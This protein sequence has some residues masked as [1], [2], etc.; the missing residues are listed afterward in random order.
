VYVAPAT[1][2]KLRRLIRTLDELTVRTWRDGPFTVLEEYVVRTGV[3][4]DQLKIDSLEAKRTV[5][6][7]GNFMRF[8]HDWQAEHPKG[9]LAGFVDYL[10]AYQS[11]G[12]EL[13]TSIE[14]TDDLQG[15]QLMTLYQAKGLEF[16]HVFVPQLLKDEWPAREYGSGLFPK[17]LLRE[18]VPTGDIHLEEERR[19]LYVALTRARERLVLT[20]ISGPAAD[21][22]TSPFLVE[23][24]E[25]RARS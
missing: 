16:D 5:A 8:A 2:A 15:V 4:L 21:K 10:D 13:P 12:G 11:A 6:N 20:S 17:E 1:R 24:R 25:G 7:I 9:T 18:A 14:A 23:E 3:V 22:E 19:L